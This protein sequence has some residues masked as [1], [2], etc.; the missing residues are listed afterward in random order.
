MHAWQGNMLV[1]MAGDGNYNMETRHD[2]R[3]MVKVPS[4]D[5]LAFGTFAAAHPASP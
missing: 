3:F 4:A 2:D 5:F 1:D